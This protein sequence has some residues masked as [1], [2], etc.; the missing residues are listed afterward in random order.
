[1]N[2]NPSRPLTLQGTPSVAD[3]GTYSIKVTATDTNGQS[4]STTYEVNVI[5][6][7]NPVVQTQINDQQID[8]NKEFLLQLDPSTFIDTNGDILTYKAV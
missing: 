6:N 1:M 7:Y 2:Y 3:V 5:Q 4:T 8:L